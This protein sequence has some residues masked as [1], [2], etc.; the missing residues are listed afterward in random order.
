MFSK[1]IG[2]ICGILAFLVIV[3]SV[4]AAIANYPNFSF[5]NNWLSDL[6]VGNSAVFFNSGVMIAGV[7][8]L[9]FSLAFS[10]KN[11][12]GYLM[13]I[14]SLALVGVGL[15][16]ENSMPE[17]SHFYFSAAFFAAMSLSMLAAGIL[18]RGFDRYFSLLTFFISII[19]LA[20]L[21]QARSIITIAVFDLGKGAISEAIAGLSFGIFA[22]VLGYRM[23]KGK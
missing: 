7:L 12:A 11:K 1:K 10:R 17:N 6:G 4:T 22:L 8:L 23:L 5:W 9:I 15:F 20:F 3:S 21:L 18:G 19:P 2:G 13:V 16:T 14:A